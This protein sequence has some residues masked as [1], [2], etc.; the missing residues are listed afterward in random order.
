MIKFFRNLIKLSLIL[1]LAWIG[2]TS[3][4]VLGVYLLQEA[5]KNLDN[6]ST[7]PN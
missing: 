3:F 2:T 4:I 5:T 6:G 1:S 7:F